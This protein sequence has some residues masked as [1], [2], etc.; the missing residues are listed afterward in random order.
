MSC[1]VGFY[2]S[3]AHIFCGFISNLLFF[4]LY[5]FLSFL[6]L[7]P[8]FIH[9]ISD[10]FS[11]LKRRLLE[12]AIALASRIKLYLLYPIPKDALS[13]VLSIKSFSS[14]NDS[15]GFDF[16]GPDLLSLSRLLC[17]SE[18]KTELNISV[19]LFWEKNTLL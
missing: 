19:Q 7:Y 15:L 18:L 8:Y 4:P 1:L 11:F 17:H 14:L 3:L 10:G 12:L 16:F 5:L 6:F 13:L 2:F 9:H